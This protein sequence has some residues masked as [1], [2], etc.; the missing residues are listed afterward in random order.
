[1]ASGDPAGE[2]SAV[3]KE[4]AEALAQRARDGLTTLLARFDDEATPYKAMRRGAFG[5]N[6]R[7]DAYAHLAR[8]EEW[9]GATEE[10]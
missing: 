8:V 9:S 4:S 3:T 7:F 10:G 2:E 6:Y 1:M 5:N